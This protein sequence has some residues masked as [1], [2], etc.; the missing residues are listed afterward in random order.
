MDSLRQDLRVA[1]RT[2]ARSPGFALTA[3]VALALGIGAST[4]IFSIADA[5][6]LRPAPFRDADRL[7]VFWE[8][9][10]AQGARYNE[11]APVQFRA[12]ADRSRSFEQIAAYDYGGATLTGS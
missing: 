1:A 8:E 5:L 4:A 12:V 6:I 10:A 3:I 7:V 11:V 2:I 9:N